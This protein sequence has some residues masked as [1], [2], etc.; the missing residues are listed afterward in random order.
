MFPENTERHSGVQVCTQAYTSAK[1]V[2]CRIELIFQHRGAGP[3]LRGEGGLGICQ[4]F[5]EVGLQGRMLLPS[6]R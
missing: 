1:T 5:C 4:C 6:T 3:Q 2:V